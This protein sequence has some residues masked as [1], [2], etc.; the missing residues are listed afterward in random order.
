MNRYRLSVTKILF[1]TLLLALLAAV[2]CSK[3]EESQVDAAQDFK[4]A[5]EKY[6]MLDNRDVK[7]DLMDE[8]VNTYP[9][10][11]MTGRAV[12][13]VVYNRHLVKDDYAGAL[14]YLNE[15]LAETV[16]PALTR[17]MKLQKIEVLASLDRP[18]ELASLA[19]ELLDSPEGLSGGE[20]QQVLTS[21]TEAEAWSLAEKISDMLLEDLGETEDKYSLSSVLAK[22]AHVLHNQDRNGEA[23]KLFEEAGSLA[24]RNFAGYFEYPVMDLEYQ[25]ASALLA[26]GKPEDALEVFDF[27]GLFVKE[28]T[29]ETHNTHQ[30]L[31]KELYLESGRDESS[32]EEYKAER[33]NSLSRQVPEFSAPD[34]SSGKQ[35]VFSE[36]KG[37]KATMLVFW[38]PT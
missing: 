18:D 19:A 14:S 31:L 26:A 25:W 4:A 9:D 8:F 5:Y 10:S 33:K 30:A 6:R 2:S 37:E 7:A 12:G 23:L 22:K 13:L 16:N 3:G 32:F 20:K 24:P 29:P 21:A 35:L 38:F 27:R 28:E 36:L 17:S 15:K 1:L 11:E 34:S